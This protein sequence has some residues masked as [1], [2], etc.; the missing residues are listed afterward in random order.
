MMSVIDIAAAVAMFLVALGIIYA[1]YSFKF[2]TC[3]KK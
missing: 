1:A 2:Q 3:E